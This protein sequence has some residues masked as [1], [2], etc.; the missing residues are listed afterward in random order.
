MITTFF[1]EVG[2]IIYTILFR[3]LNLSVRLIVFI[4]AA[5]AVF[6]LAEFGVCESLGLGNSTWAKIGFSA[7]TLLPPFG[8]HLVFTMARKKSKLIPIAYAG[9]AVWVG[10]F[11]FGNIMSGA[12]C[13]GNYVIFNF[14]DPFEGLYY[15]F[16][17]I[18][19]FVTMALGLLFARGAK[20]VKT[21]K[22]LHWLVI[23]Y[24]SFIVPA[25]IF[26]QIDSRTGSDSTLPSILCGFAILLALIIVLRVLPMVSNRKHI[27]P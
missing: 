6:Q 13:E 20:K 14:A 5:L 7:T 21:K 22:A 27:K 23:G 9:A 12:V 17:D 25:M 15:I 16:Y 8:L 18:I 26:A 1:I 19:L 3:K 10:F 2:L 11:V 4:I 24:A